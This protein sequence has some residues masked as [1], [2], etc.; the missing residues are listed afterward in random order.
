MAEG[1]EVKVAA[2]GHLWCHL[3]VSHTSSCPWLLEQLQLVLACCSSS[4][5]CVLATHIG[6]VSICGTCSSMSLFCNG[7]WCWQPT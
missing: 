7:G 2:G 6:C 4:T 3:G 1:E 5:C